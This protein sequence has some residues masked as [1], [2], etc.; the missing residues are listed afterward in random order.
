MVVADGRSEVRNVGGRTLIGYR[1]NGVRVTPISG[2]F[3]GSVRRGSTMTGGAL[4]R[5][6]AVGAGLSVALGGVVAIVSGVVSGAADEAVL[7]VVSTVFADPPESRDIS[8]TTDTS[9][10][11]AGNS[12][13]ADRRHRGGRPI[14]GHGRVPAVTIGPVIVVEPDVVVIEPGVR[15]GSADVVLGVAEGLPQIVE[16]A[17]RFGYRHE[18]HGTTLPDRQ[19]CASTR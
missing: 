1:V 9:I 18:R 2:G 7:A 8:R 15:A 16:V 17:R 10:A 5:S 4:A 13:R 19:S 12:D 3:V 6:D 11:I 14:P